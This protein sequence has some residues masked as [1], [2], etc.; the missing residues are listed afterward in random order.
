MSEA[1]RSTSLIAS[2]EATLARADLDAYVAALVLATGFHD[3][4]SSRWAA[5]VNALLTQV[6]QGSARPQDVAIRGIRCFLG[7][8]TA[9]RDDYALLVQREAARKPLPPAVTLRDDDRVL[10]GI[11]AGVG[12]MATARAGDVASIARVQAATVR[13]RVLRLW[14]EALCSGTAQFTPTHIATAMRLLEEAVPAS[15]DD[16]AALLWLGMRVLQSGTTHDDAL[17]QLDPTLSDLRRS[18]G[19]VA[20]AALL[21]V[22]VAL[23]VDAQSAIAPE[24]LVR[25]SALERVLQLL[26]QFGGSAAIVAKRYG[27]RPPFVISDEY[28]VQDLFHALVL[29]IA[30]DCEAEDPTPKRAGKS[31]R[32]DFVSRQLRMGFE[33]KFVHDTGHTEKLRRE[34]LLDEATYHEHPYVERVVAF[35][36]DP[37]RHITPL[38]RGIL[39]RDLSASVTIDGRS[40]QYYVRI[41]G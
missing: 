10:I 29:P 19:T 35:L 11:A 16:R 13:A 5:D 1:L 14:A 34:I 6:D 37:N 18:L 23:L 27:Q 31:S 33:M 36:Y 21:P 39:E 4:R 24:R 41:R 17:A 2:L 28:D 30:P 12:A 22:S 26:D 25:A 32:L 8:A 9:P 15:D 7:D 20:A 40:V 38:D 3:W